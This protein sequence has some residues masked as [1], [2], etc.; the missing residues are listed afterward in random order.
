MQKPPQVLKN[1][2]KI[3]LH[4]F[5]CTKC[6]VIKPSP[7]LKP[8]HFLTDLHSNFFPKCR[9]LTCKA[10]DI[11]WSVCWI[12]VTGNRNLLPSLTSFFVAHHGPSPRALSGQTYSA[13][14]LHTNMTCVVLATLLIISFWEQCQ[15]FLSFFLW[16]TGKASLICTLSL[17]GK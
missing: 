15:L 16:L 12:L 13:F 7:L 9:G 14:A 3:Q 11:T 10:D 5:G 6:D 1:I 2:W 4:I 17:K 8:N